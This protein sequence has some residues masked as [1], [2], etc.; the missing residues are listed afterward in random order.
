MNNKEGN[1]LLI[2]AHHDDEVLF[3]YSILCKKYNIYLITISDVN[4]ENSDSNANKKLKHKKEMNYLDIMKQF[5]IVYKQLN[6][7][8]FYK[9]NNAEYDNIQTRLVDN[10]KKLSEIKS[11]I[12]EIKS[13]IN[14]INELQE[15]KDELQEKKDE[16]QEKKDELVKS[17][18]ILKKKERMVI[19]NFKMLKENVT[20]YNE[21]YK[22]IENTITSF[23]IIFDAIYTHNKYGEYGHIH[24]K[25]VNYIVK[26]MTTNDNILQDITVMTPANEITK[27]R[28]K[29][30]IEKKHQILKQYDFKDT[31]LKKN[32]WFD[33]CIKQYD[34]WANNDYEY[35]QLI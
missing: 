12:N 23:G 20:N 32:V 29:I 28:N 9:N 1:I 5:N 13:R 7:Q 15:K 17:N 25:I 26:S 10:N 18:N 16:L 35:F 27:I 2:L 33:Q 14:E 19:Q 8:F 22:N 11:R 30:D 31:E 3:F 4:N 6:L 21:L 34:F 24:H